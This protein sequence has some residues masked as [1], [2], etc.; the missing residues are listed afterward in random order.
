MV[1]PVGK[2]TAS[3][4]ITHTLDNDLRVFLIAPSG[5][6]VELT[7]NNGGAGQNYGSACGVDASRTTF[8]DAAPTSITTGHGTVPRKFPARRFARHVQRLD[9]VDMNGV[10]KLRVID[11]VGGDTAP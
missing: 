10:W 11:S 8:D 7:S 1:G 2:V 5:A 3:M 9:G 4:F 6:S